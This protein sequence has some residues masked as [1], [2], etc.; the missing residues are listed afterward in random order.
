MYKVKCKLTGGVDRYK[1]R[2]VVKGYNQ[3]NG[4]DFKD[5]FPP[6]AKLTTVRI[7]IALAT[8]KH[9]PIFQLGINNAF[10]H[11]FLNEEVYMVPPQGYTHTHTKKNPFMVLNKHP[12]NGTLNSLLF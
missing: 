8:A 7:F 12:S 5:H 9:W 6:V 11:N 10:L 4:L 2:L 1:A 3:I